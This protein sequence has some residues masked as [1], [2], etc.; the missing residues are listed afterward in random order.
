[1]KEF[2]LVKGAD[3]EIAQWQEEL[4]ELERDCSTGKLGTTFEQKQKIDLLLDRA[5]ARKVKRVS[6]SLF[7][8]LLDKHCNQES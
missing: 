2:D 5:R 4:S 6:D 1:M 7:Q 3:E 8:K